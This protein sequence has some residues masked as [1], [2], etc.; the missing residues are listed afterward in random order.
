MNPRDPL[1]DIFKKLEHS[2]SNDISSKE[3]VWAMLENK[4]EQ[5]ARKR[6]RA[7]PQSEMACR[8]CSNI[9]C[10]SYLSVCKTYR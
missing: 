3:K 2:E 10:R 4:L 8:C 6:Q 9:V 7:F 1:N 5:P